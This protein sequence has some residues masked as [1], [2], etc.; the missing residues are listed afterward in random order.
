MTSCSVTET[1]KFSRL[2]KDWSLKIML[3]LCLLCVEYMERCS[4]SRTGKVHIAV[5]QTVGTADIL[6]VVGVNSVATGQ[7]L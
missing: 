1:E 5:T 6:C 2:F 7:R 3:V 4:Y